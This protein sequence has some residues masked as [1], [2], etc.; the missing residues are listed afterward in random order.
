[1]ENDVS[2]VGIPSYGKEI[3]S[4]IRMRENARYYY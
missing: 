4:Y 2:Y 3:L 1:M